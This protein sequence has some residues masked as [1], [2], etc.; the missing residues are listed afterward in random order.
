M[1]D[2]KS[3]QKHTMGAGLQ[4][5]K[6]SVEGDRHGGLKHRARAEVDLLSLGPVAYTILRTPLKEKIK[7]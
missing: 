5:G 6:K 3:T 7:L 4:R 1:D 2:F